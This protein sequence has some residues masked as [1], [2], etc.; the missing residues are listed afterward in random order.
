MIVTTERVEGLS[1]S[2]SPSPVAEKVANSSV[3]TLESV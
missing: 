1:S 3:C 2:L